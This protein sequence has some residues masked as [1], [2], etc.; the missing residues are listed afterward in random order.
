MQLINWYFNFPLITWS[1]RMQ[2][3]LHPVLRSS[4]LQQKANKQQQRTKAINNHLFVLIQGLFP[5]LFVLLPA[6]AH[7]LL[8]T[9]NLFSSQRCANIH[10][11]ISYLNQTISC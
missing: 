8:L 11:M 1:H 4:V 3:H 7:K 10:I 9:K 6:L 2:S 5:P